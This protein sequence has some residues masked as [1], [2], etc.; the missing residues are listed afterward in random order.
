MNPGGQFVGGEAE[1]HRG[2]EIET[3]RAL[4]PVI[5]GGM[6]HV[7]DA[8]RDGIEHLKRADEL[9]RSENLNLEAAAGVRRDRAAKSFSAAAKTGKAFRPARHHLELPG[10]LCDGRSRKS[11]RYAGNNA[12]P[13]QKAAS[14]HGTSPP[15]FS[16]FWETTFRA[17]L[18]PI[19]R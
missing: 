7:G 1:R 9:S 13:G 16:C 15:V 8:A 17:E 19:K 4:L 14:I 12:G 11:G 6:I 2:E 10:T 5:L 18:S 3:G